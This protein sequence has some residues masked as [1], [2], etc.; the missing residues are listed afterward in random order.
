VVSIKQKETIDPL[1]GIGR[2]LRFML[3]APKRIKGIGSRTW[4]LNHGSQTMKKFK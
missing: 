2:L 1:M 3:M 4:T